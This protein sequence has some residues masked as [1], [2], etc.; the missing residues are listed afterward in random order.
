MG[1]GPFAGRDAVVKALAGA[2]A[3]RIF[4]PETME[5]HVDHV[6]VEGDTAVVQQTLTA[7]TRK[8][9]DY[10]NEYCWVYTCVGRQGGPDGRVHRLLPRGQDLRHGAVVVSP[11]GDRAAVAGPDDRGRHRP[12]PGHLRPPPPPWA[13]PPMAAR[14]PRARR[15]E[16]AEAAVRREDRYLAR[17]AAGR[18]RLRA[19]GC[20]RRCSSSAARPTG[21]TARRAA[22]ASVRPSSSSPRRGR[23]RRRP[24]NRHPHRRD[25]GVRRPAPGRGGGRRARG[26]PGG[27]ATA[28]SAASATR[29]PG[30]RAPDHA[31]TGPTRAEGLL[32][33]PAFQ[34][35]V[36]ALGPRRA[37]LRRLALPPP[38]A[39]ARSS[40]PAPRRAPRSSSTTWADRSASAP[41]P[42]VTRR[43]WP[44][45]G[46]SLAELAE[47]PHVRLKL[48][49]IGMTVFG[50]RWHRR[51]APPS[52]QELAAFWA[53][54][55]RWCID[56]FGPDRAMFESNF[57]PDRASCS[58]VVL[59]NAFKRMAGGYSAGRAG[60]AV[61]RHGAGHLPADRAA[62]PRAL[63]AASRSR[64]CRRGLQFARGPRRS[65]P[66]GRRRTDTTTEGKRP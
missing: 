26:T 48:G 34:E 30:T 24:G 1:I 39:R 56:R 27:R 38:A 25:R 13:R 15:T 52:S 2:A 33:D 58:Y 42:A 65:R 59:W 54:H 44:P 57:P 66:P 46:R 45:A 32:V 23:R 17:R 20:S 61:P 22:A 12:R 43:C 28:A 10:R 9:A 7:T 14:P 51:E 49:G 11:P 5:R 37:D 21:P 55:V 60:P 3:G 63:P 47:L 16:A 29:S 64:E 50:Q 6:T 36:R 53:D 40:W 35:G 31:T 18:H 4:Q 62:S 41:T 19:T 8:G